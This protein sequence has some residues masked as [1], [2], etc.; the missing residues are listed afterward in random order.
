[1]NMDVSGKSKIQIIEEGI[2]ATES[3]YSQYGIAVNYNE[4]TEV[5]EM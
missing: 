1:M 2:A 5:P 3:I 4:I